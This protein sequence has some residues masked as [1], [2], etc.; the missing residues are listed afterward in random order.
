MLVAAAISGDEL[1]FDRLVSR[2][3]H[4]AF[5]EAA[6][7]VGSSR[8]EDVV[9]DARLLARR[10]LGSLKDPSRFSRW[11][12]A[13]TRWLAL[14]AGNPE[15]RHALAGVPLEESVL[16]TLSGLASAPRSSA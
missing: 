12:V 11:L 5:R 13:I 9:H 10:A 14:R 7:I 4:S 15:S 3:R 6:R 16:E 2:H 8:A 1:A